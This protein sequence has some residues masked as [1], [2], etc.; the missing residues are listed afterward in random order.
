VFVGDAKH[1]PQPPSTILPPKDAQLV[2]LI[3]WQHHGFDGGVMKGNIYYSLRVRRGWDG[4]TVTDPYADPRKPIVVDLGGGVSALVPITL[5]ADQTGTFPHAKAKVTAA[6][7][8]VVG[9]STDD[10]AVRL[11]DVALAWTIFQHFY[12]Y[13][14]VV[15][16]D[17]PAAL[18]DALIDAAKEADGVAFE[19]TLSHL[20]AN[21]HDG[22]GWVTSGAG[23]NR[24]TRPPITWGIVEGKLVVLTIDD[25]AKDAVDGV[26]PGDIVVSI[27][28][29]PAKDVL[30]AA[31]AF[32]PSATP[33][34][35]E[36]RAL[37]RILGGGKDS[38]ITL[39]I[40]SPGATTTRKVVLTRSTGLWDWA[41]EK[42]P[43]KV[44][45]LERGIWYVDIDRIDDSDFQAALPKLAKAK[46]IVF[47]LRGYPNHNSNPYLAHLSDKQIQSALWNVPIITRPDRQS[48]TWDTSGRWMIDPV[49]PRLTAKIAFLVDGR[50]I[51]Q[52][53][54][55]MGI[56]EAYKLAE[57]VGS[58]TAG[59]NGNIAPFTL[60]GDVHV[61]FT[62]MRVLKHDGSQHH[63]VGIAP[64]VPVSRTIA[65]VAAGKDEILLAACK[66]VG[67]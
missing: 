40:Q 3:T 30:T 44:A 10:R 9:P 59:T 13:F 58:T 39:E 17:W 23:S 53:E 34:W 32:E 48:W 64:T 60:P 1:A 51:S 2:D 20:V 15:N 33:Q 62:G 41:T 43:A 50:S 54:S 52:A 19:D 22:H 4:E 38:K 21:L 25:G 55:V 31:L 12:P 5:F 8:S 28:G 49:A 47:D 56:I 63:G 7:T 36:W 65:G 57:I 67:G 27:D 24:K 37:M 45:E 46:G 14:D 66:L 18:T 29:T 11:A 16:T 35:A 26:A 61:S 42:R 6:A